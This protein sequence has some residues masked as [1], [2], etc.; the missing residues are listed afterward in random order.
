VIVEVELV[1]EVKSQ[2]VQDR[3]RGNDRAFYRREIS[4][5]IRRMSSSCEIEELS[6]AMFHNKTSIEE[7]FRHDIV[8]IE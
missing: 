4:R 8:T 1:V 5:R 6:F 7:D 2:V 3:F